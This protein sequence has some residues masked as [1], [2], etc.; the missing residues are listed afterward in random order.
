MLVNY[1]VSP[2]G[3]RMYIGFHPVWR[4]KTIKQSDQS[5]QMV[6]LLLLPYVCIHLNH[7]QILIP[8]QR[9]H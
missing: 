3:F 7:Q 2:I 1:L 5:Y 4:Y 8:E 9:I 6:I